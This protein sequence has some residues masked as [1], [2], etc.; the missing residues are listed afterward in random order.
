MRVLVL[1]GPSLNLLGQREPAIYG[2][3]DLASIDASLRELA[4]E[5]GAAIEC[6]QSNHEG[7]LIDWIHEAAFPR[8]ASTPPFD[9]LMINP[10]AYTHTSIAIRD[11][12][13]ATGL[14]TVEVHLSNVHAREA[15]RHRS[16][17][18]AVCVGQITGFGA[19]SYAL[20]LRAL[21]GYLRAR[22]SPS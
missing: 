8:D 1:H 13:A 3:A 14:P 10:G 18:A 11:A 12:I 15:F 2:A 19:G 20:G 16:R 22:V 5:L 17:I 7:A 4:G 6:R 21:V 9:A